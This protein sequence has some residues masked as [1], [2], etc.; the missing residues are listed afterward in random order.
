M[1]L[2]NIDVR[3]L[4]PPEPMTAILHALAK[5]PH[6]QCLLVHHSR[7]PFPLYEK[8]NSAGWAYYCEAKAGGEFFI[9]IYRQI[10]QSEFER[11]IQSQGQF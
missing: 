4:A 7:Q 2:V 6:D 1:N 9:Y 5:L 10:L 8:L 11:F 3:E